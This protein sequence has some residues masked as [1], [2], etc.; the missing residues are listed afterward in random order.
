MTPCEC[1]TTH[2]LV[3]REGQAHQQDK[4]IAGW[5]VGIC[6]YTDPFLDMGE[7]NL[8]RPAYGMWMIWLWMIRLPV[9]L[10]VSF[11]P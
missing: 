8:T 4:E 6:M 9:S 1:I 11:S 2:R 10:R 3:L 5:Y 7:V